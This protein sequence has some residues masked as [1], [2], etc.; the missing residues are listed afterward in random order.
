[1]TSTT[2]AGE[3]IIVIS[4]KIPRWQESV[5]FSWAVLWM[6]CGIAVIWQIFGEWPREQ[7]MYM[8]IFLVFWAY[9]AYKGLYAL[10]WRL[11]G[12]EMIKVTP[13]SILVKRD[14]KSYGKAIR[15]QRD[16]IKDVRL[17]EQDD[18]SFATVYHNSF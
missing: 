17:N 15:Y 1:M 6:F 2:K 4:G 7:K 13:E 5:L 9:F 3:T 12:K 8:L 18:R 16:N 11:W 10:V 14:I